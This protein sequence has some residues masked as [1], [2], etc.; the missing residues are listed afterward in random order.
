MFDVRN[1]ETINEL[2]D[3][4]N[5]RKGFDVAMSNPKNGKLIIKYNNTS[6]FL[7]ITPIYKQGIKEDSFDCVVK[8][9][10]LFFE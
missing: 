4:L 7:E 10:D 1:Y 9:N 3:A 2:F 8:R 5:K 6:F